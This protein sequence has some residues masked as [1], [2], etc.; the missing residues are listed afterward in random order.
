MAPLLFIPIPPMIK[1]FRLSL[2]NIVYNV[3]SSIS[4]AELLSASIYV[5]IVTV[6]TYMYMYINYIIHNRP[7]FII[8]CCILLTFT[9]SVLLYHLIYLAN[10]IMLFIQLFNLISLILLFVLLLLTERL[11]V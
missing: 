11:L 5:I 6:H 4:A 2:Y 9:T 7:Y 8:I 3:F 1:L 10:Y